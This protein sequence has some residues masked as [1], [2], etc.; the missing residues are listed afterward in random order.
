MIASNIFR[1]IG[2]FFTDFLFLPFQWLRTNLALVD[3][4]WWISNAVSW[5]FIVILLCLFAYWMKESR[6]FKRE[7][8][9]DKA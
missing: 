8:I 7:G 1:W 3:F 6:R 2:S 4:G 5:M 9:E